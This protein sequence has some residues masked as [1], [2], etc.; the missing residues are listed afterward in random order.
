LLRAARE[1][2]TI[3]VMLSAS[4]APG[5]TR[6]II[7]LMSG[8]SCDGIDAALAAISGSG[9]TLRATLED[10]LCVPYENAM[11]EKLLRAAEMNAGE[12]ALLNFELGELLADA[13][14]QLIARQAGGTPGL[15]I[16]A[17]ASH[18]HTVCHLPQQNATLQIGESAMIANTTG[19]TTVSDFRV[20][21]VAAG[22]QGAPL[23]PYV[24]WCLLRSRSTHR[25]IQNIGGI[26][27]CTILPAN[28]D[29]EDVRAWDTGPGNMI[30]DECARVLTNGKLQYD[31]DGKLAAQGRADEN[32]LRV[33]L[34]HEYFFRPPP[35]SCGR[36]EFGK[37]FAQ[38]FLTEGA[39]RGLST[40][41]LMATA[42]ALTAGSIAHAYRMHAAPLLINGELEIILG[43]GGAFNP[44]LRQMLQ[45][46]VSAGHVLTHEEIGAA[47]DAREALAFAVLAHETLNGVPSNV[48]GA[49]GARKSV[50]LGK[51]A[52][53]AHEFN[54]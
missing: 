27:N 28:C 1:S 36:E 40:P 26:A 48:P 24:D 54:T 38:Q 39:R 42:T 44:T 53:G 8:T 14:Q 43:G 22:G 29:L 23:I 30:L 51:I 17:I 31:E 12:L 6:H 3:F 10:F 20:A 11:R 35:V 50:M 52:F 47:S 18:G 9:S 13:A 5:K 33:L 41:D 16:D 37:F 19:I 34:G 21:D 7:G 15:K 49:T 32:W 46:R 2:I 45:A 25:I 4:D